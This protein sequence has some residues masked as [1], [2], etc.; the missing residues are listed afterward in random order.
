MK[1]EEFSANFPQVRTALQTKPR[2]RKS[3]AR[4]VLEQKVEE[5]LMQRVT[6]LGGI[7]LKLATPGVPGAP[8]RIVFLPGKAPILVELK[9]IGGVLEPSQKKWQRITKFQPTVLWTIEQVDT[10]AKRVR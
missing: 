2:R 3:R 5:R 1:H 4:T 8:D 6:E 7:A 9:T 10:W